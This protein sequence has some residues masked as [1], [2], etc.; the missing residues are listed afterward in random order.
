MEKLRELLNEFDPY[1]AK[2]WEHRDN[3]WYGVICW[4]SAI[5]TKEIWIQKII[6]KEYGF[7]KRLV[8]NDKI[9]NDLKEIKVCLKK[10][11]ELIEFEWGIDELLIM[12]L[13]I[14]ETPIEDLISYLK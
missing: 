11:N 4:E 8:D 1:I 12:T 13:S 7:I 9:E 5:F 10:W 2:D 6:S 14:S 3:L